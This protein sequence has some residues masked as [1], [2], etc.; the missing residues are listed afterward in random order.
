MPDIANLQSTL[1]Q[2]RQELARLEAELQAAQRATLSRLPADAGFDSA[3][4]LIRA[5]AEF[6]SPRLQAAVAS[7]FGNQRGG[8][9]ASGDE[10]SRKKRVTVTDELREQIAAEIKRGELGANEIASK[11]DVSASTVNQL[12]QRLGLTRARAKHA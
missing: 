5:L 10:R 8:S 12:K 6:A 11:F 3:D 2:K 4:S 7:A 1:D 9:A